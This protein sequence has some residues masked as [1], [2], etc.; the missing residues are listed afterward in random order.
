MYL[1][2]DVGGTK[3]LVAV[4]N[5]DG[6][7]RECTKFPTPKNYDHFLLELRHTLAHFEHKDFK[8][9]GIAIP[10]YIDREHGRAG[11]LGNLKSWG[12]AL[13]VQ[14]DL[15]RIAHCPIVVENDAKLA[16]LSE[17]M[18]LKDKYSKVLYMTVSTGIGLALINEQTIDPN[19]GDGGGETILVE[20]QG[21]SARWEDI[22]SGKA[23][24]ERYGKRAMDITDNA[25]WQKIS[26]DIAKGLNEVIAVTEPEVVVI[27]GSVGT[28]F[29]RYSKLLKQELDAYHMPVLKMPALRS[30]QRPE[31]AVV[32]G[33]YDLAKQRFAHSAHAAA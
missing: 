12:N 31:E 21:K 2:V 24:V 7:I 28:Y 30:A 19:I 32:Y 1:G 23:I 6:E 22:A 27:G 15:E 10:G 25:T 9:G 8:A 18:L 3:T 29:D 13:P 17:A 20:H 26:R 33:C 16:G 5:N 4:L 11:H 14:R